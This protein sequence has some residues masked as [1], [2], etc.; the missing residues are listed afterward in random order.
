MICCPIDAINVRWVGPPR[1]AST[2][3]QATV[4]YKVP[5]AAKAARQVAHWRLASQ[6]R[7]HPSA[8]R[9]CTQGSSHFRLGYLFFRRPQHTMRPLTKVSMEATGWS[10]QP[11]GMQS[12]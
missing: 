5:S 11:Q 10:G 4:P 8:P 3:V 12:G 6:S 1:E 2:S 9:A 7:G